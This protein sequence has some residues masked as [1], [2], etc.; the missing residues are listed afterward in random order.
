MKTYLSRK[1]NS[2][3]TADFNRNS[4]R[5]KQTLFMGPCFQ[6][7]LPTR[8]ISEK[9]TLHFLLKCGS[10][11]RSDFSIQHGDKRPNNSVRSD[12]I[13]AKDLGE[14]ANYENNSENICKKVKISKEPNDVILPSYNL[15]YSKR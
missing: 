4:K 8:D 6:T 2:E 5:P 15:F 14:D 7:Q 3:K 13:L 11:H 10:D 1:F 12:L 9:N